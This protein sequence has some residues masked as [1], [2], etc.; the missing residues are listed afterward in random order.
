MCF[1]SPR[2]SASWVAAS[3][4]SV[5]SPIFSIMRGES[6]RPGSSVN[7]FGSYRASN[8]MPACVSCW[9]TLAHRV[10]SPAVHPKLVVASKLVRIEEIGNASD[11]NVTEA[12]AKWTFFEL[13]FRLRN[14]PVELHLNRLG[15]HVRLGDHFGAKRFLQPHLSRFADVQDARHDRLKTFRHLVTRVI[16]PVPI[17]DQTHQC[18]HENAHRVI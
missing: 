15:T 4:N 17:F 5:S 10:I 3:T 12:C 1:M 6:P 13:R 16:G 9:W 11:F 14:D 2:A 18:S 8:S 7:D